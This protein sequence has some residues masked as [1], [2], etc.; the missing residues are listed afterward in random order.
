MARI[1]EL[2]NFLKEDPSD[3][4]ALYALALEYIKMNHI[5]EAIS[6]LEE[7]L[8][9][10]PQ[11]LAAYYQLGKLFEQQ[12]DSAKASSTFSKG[13]EVAKTKSDQ[14][15]FNELQSALDSLE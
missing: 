11:Y 3:N 8:Q 6:L 1:D 7:L 2:K 10:N 13:M 5:S 4:F 9:R 14:K 15:T 12:H